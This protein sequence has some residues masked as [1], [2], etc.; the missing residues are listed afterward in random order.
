M[1][2]FIFYSITGKNIPQ[3]RM[4]ALFIGSSTYINSNKSLPSAKED[5]EAVKAFF[6]C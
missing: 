3:V 1:L 5:V 4:K 6:D 2:I